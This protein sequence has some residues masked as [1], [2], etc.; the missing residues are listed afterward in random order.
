MEQAKSFTRE[1]TVDITSDQ[2]GRFIGPKGSAIKKF[3]IMKSINSFTHGSAPDNSDDL[4]FPKVS[5]N[6]TKDGVMAN[7]SSHSEDL[8]DIVVENIGLHATSLR[9]LGTNSPNKI[10][11]LVF[12]TNLDDH[13]IG[14][15][16]GKSGRH[17]KVLANLLQ[18]DANDRNIDSASSFRVNITKPEREPRK[19]FFIKNSS[20]SSN[21]VFIYVTAIYPG[22]PRTLFKAV[23]NR[24][25]NSVTSLISDDIANSKPEPEPEQSDQPVLS[26]EYFLIHNT[27]ESIVAELSTDSEAPLSPTY[28]PSSPTYTPSSPTIAGWESYDPGSEVSTW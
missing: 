11:R 23:Q 2:I 18:E 9:A 10:C 8:I 12:K 20:S 4:P 5:L 28:T 15:Y 13:L 17:C 27:P 14:K 3:V 21:M 16:I 24:M 1:I 19:F 22:N 26:A 7:I 25:I 6:K